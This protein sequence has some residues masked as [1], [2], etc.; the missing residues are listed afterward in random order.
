ML[1]RKSVVIAAVVAACAMPVTAQDAA[2]SPKQPEKQPAPET[3]LLTIGDRAPE[4][5]VSSWVKGERVTGFEKGQ[6]Y[7]LDF[8]ATW[9]GPC[10]AAI[11]HMTETQAKYKDKGVNIIGVSVWESDQ[12]KVAPFVAGKGD[13]MNYRVAN[14]DCPPYPEG[15]AA[16]SREAQRWNIDNG[17][18]SKAWMKAAGRNGIPTVFIVNQEGRIAWIGH[19]MSGMDDALEQIVAGKW[20]IRKAADEYRAQQ[21]RQ[22]AANALSGRVNEYARLLRSGE[23][24]KAYAIGR[25]L[26]SGPGKDNPMLL[27][28]IAWLIVDPAGKVEKKDLDLAIKAATQACE[29]TKW[30]DGAIIDTLALATFLKG[31]VD[32]AIE[33]QTKAIALVG[34]NEDMKTELE[35]RL[36]EFKAAKKK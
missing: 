1:G 22:A 30:K 4:L 18:M 19:P 15:V 27:N 14:D 26:V 8:W 35:G 33:L 6:V 23:T 5:T 11:P 29:V 24:D 17:K 16:G 32:K 28:Q 25:E 31:D 36:A 13:V 7:V 21:E 34:D 10:I 20:D 12:A 3:K 9:C 2:R